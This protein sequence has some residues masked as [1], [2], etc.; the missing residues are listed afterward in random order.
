MEIICFLFDKSTC[1]SFQGFLH[2]VERRDVSAAAVSLLDKFNGS[3][4][5]RIHIVDAEVPFLHICLCL[6]DGDLAQRLFVFLPHINAYL[7]DVG[8]DDEHIG[9]D[10]LGRRWHL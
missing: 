6:I 4:E 3:T 7:L 2:F 9:V 1:F 8:K 10:S 5:L